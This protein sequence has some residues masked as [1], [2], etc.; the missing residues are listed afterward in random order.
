MKDIDLKKYFAIVQKV[1]SQV[2]V[3]DEEAQYLMEHI[4]H[5]Q[6][7]LDE[8]NKKID[9]AQQSGIVPKELNE[10]AAFQA[11]QLFM[12]SPAYKTQM[13]KIIA[14]ADSGKLSERLTSAF[15]IALSGGDVAQSINQIE[16]SKTLSKQ[17][18]RPTR[19]GP[20]VSDQNLAH[21]LR[22]AQEGTYDVSK[23][24]APAQA[25]TQDQ[26]N[27]DI[28]NAKIASTGQ[29]GA[30]GNYVQAAANRR[31]RAGLEQSAL[32]SQI[33]MQNRS[34][35]NH[36]LGLKQQENQNVFNSQMA[37][38]PYDL[39]Q[40]QSEQQASAKLGQ[41]GRE[42]LRN[43]L[44]N[45]GQTFTTGI[46]NEAKQRKLRMLQ[47]MMGDN[48]STAYDKLYSYVSPNEE[49]PASPGYDFPDQYKI[50]GAYGI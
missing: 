9:K 50:Q 41:Y 5:G 20:I 16:Q 10:Q 31:N 39:N 11:A 14:D 2:A 25:Q 17:S 27:A 42:N 35:Y 34:N 32:G 47:S 4:P 38:Y 43:S 33:M 7:E 15:N 40:Y 13:A 22:Q 36:L 44:A 37:S 23:Q 28:A 46:G 19:P 29:A 6:D 26:Y 24:L 48:A 3:T 45:L 21:A 49:Q 12:Q 30:F 18:T 8:L 1:Q